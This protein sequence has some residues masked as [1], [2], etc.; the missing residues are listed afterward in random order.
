M[1]RSLIK[2]KLGREREKEGDINE[3][4]ARKDGRAEGG[5]Q[6]LQ[7]LYKNKFESFRK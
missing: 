2:V 6:I 4:K 7:K 1:L 5:E 3:R